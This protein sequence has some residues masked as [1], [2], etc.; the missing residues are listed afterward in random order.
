MRGSVVRVLAATVAALIG[1]I[2]PV[3][4]QWKDWDYNLDQEKKPWAE[5]QAQLPPYPKP[6]N[7]A[8]LQVG[9]YNA[10]EHFVDT[11]S[12]SVGEDGVVRYTLV[13]KTRGGA[14]NVTFEGIRC[15]G[16]EV[17][18]YAAGHPGNQWSRLNQSSWRPIEF[19]N[20]QGHHNVLHREYYCWTASRGETLTLKEILTNLRL[21]PQHPSDGLR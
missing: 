11:T 10:N 6:E 12:I 19:R 4:A 20:L 14:T 2:S 1:C 9:E 16:R 21:G 15:N 3:A 7:L 13:I 18:V 5:L 8:K 17:R